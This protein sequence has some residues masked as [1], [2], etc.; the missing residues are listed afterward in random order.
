MPRR[1][2]SRGYAKTRRRYGSKGSALTGGTG[3]V[4]PQWFN[5]T[6]LNVTLG[7]SGGSLSATTNVCQSQE[8]IVPL[9]QQAMMQ[10]RG[11]KSMVMELLK[12]EFSKTADSSTIA[13]AGRLG[14]STRSI[15]G[16]AATGNKDLNVNQPH[17]IASTS[18]TAP[19]D[20]FLP[21]ATTSN[22]RYHF[23]PA[24]YNIWLT[25]VRCVL[26][27]CCRWLFC[28]PCY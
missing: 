23:T 6:D 5:L 18:F 8:S 27:F 15:T 10:S 11:S 19:A 12:V 2:Y 28:R 22:N 13:Q 1:R 24:G 4:N 20:S 26:H 14:V 25:D 21:L 9:Q 7:T 16:N 17:V 3:D